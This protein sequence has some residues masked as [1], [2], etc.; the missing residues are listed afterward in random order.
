MEE[1]GAEGAVRAASKAKRNF[2][3]SNSEDFY[4]KFKDINF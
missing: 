3:R 2:F 1:K 4:L